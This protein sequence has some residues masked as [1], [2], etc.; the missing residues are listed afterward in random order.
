MDRERVGLY[1][2]FN[3]RYFKTNGNQFLAQPTLCFSLPS[4]PSYKPLRYC[5]RLPYRIG[6]SD[7]NEDG[8]AQVFYLCHNDVLLNTFVVFSCWV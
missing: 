3:K 1:P 5:Q 2:T 6:L 7:S 8:R 4:Y